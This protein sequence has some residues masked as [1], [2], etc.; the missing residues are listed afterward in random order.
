MKLSPLFMEI[1][2]FETIHCLNFFPPRQKRHDVTNDVKV[3]FLF[4][5]FVRWMKNILFLANILYYY[6]WHVWNG[7]R[8]KVD[9]DSV[10]PRV[11]MIWK[12]LTLLKIFWQLL[13]KSCCH[14]NIWNDNKADLSEIIASFILLS[15]WI[16]FKAIYKHVKFLNFWCFSNDH[17]IKSPKCH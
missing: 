16:G 4:C 2:S 13:R 9:T 5:G 12:W 8:R 3:N 17:Y 1:W 15:T 6:P 10:L 11:C 7:I 14:G